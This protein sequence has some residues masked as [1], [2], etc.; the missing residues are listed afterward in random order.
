MKHPLQASYIPSKEVT[1]DSDLTISGIRLMV[2]ALSLI[3]DL[4]RFNCADWTLGN[5][6]QELV[7]RAI[8][9]HLSVLRVFD[10]MSLSSREQDQRLSLPS[11]PAIGTLSVNKILL[12]YLMCALICSFHNYTILST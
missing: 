3:R 7:L 11:T 1:I 8:N 2:N 5:K 4:V 10:S 9:F 6:A 12:I